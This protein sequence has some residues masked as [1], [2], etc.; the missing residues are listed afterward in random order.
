MCNIGMED[1]P[2]DNLTLII[3]TMGG[4]IGNVE[5]LYYYILFICVIYLFLSIYSDI[6]C[7][8]NTG[9]EGY[10]FIWGKKC[11]FADLLRESSIS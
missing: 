7:K 11:L 4:D 9:S 5:R 10:H 2:I 8:Y 3:T 1:Y 6:V